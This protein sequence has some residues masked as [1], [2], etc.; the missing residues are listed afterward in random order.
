MSVSHFFLLSSF[1]KS[2]W[3][4]DSETLCEETSI[5]Q[6]IGNDPKNWLFLFLIR[7]NKLCFTLLTVYIPAQE[8]DVCQQ[9]Y[10]LNHVENE[11]YQ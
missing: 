6:Y 11:K 4:V 8:I 2:E 3:R 5:S 1:I 9:C 10:L 7:G